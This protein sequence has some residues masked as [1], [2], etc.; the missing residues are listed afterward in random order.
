M[1]S[2]VH[3]VANGAAGQVLY[4]ARSFHAETDGHF[5][6]GLSYGFDDEVWLKA[7]HSSMESGLVRIFYT[8]STGRKNKTPVSIMVVVVC[9]SPYDGSTEIHEAMWYVAPEHRA[10]GHGIRLLRSLD[11]LAEEIGAARIIM[12]HLEDSVGDR[13]RD[14]LPKF[15]FRPLEITYAKNCLE[16]FR[17][18]AG[19][20][21]HD[22]E[23]V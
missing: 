19:K 3:E 22:Q 18:Q 9:A 17:L 12:T 5:P 14:I 10:A 2:G 8:T 20:V 13:L 15:G 21:D 23:V 7:M 11:D 4:L 6:A 16:S 1:K